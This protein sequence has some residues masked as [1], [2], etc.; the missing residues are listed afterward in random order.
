MHPRIDRSVVLPEPEGPMSSVSSPVCSS[1]STPLSTLTWFGASPRTL[2][3]P[4]ASRMTLL[5]AGWDMGR[6]LLDLAAEDHGRI[7]PDHFDDGAD[8]GED[9]HADRNGEQRQSKLG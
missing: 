3:M 1:R 7:D 5:F 8:G 2:T 6:V 9:T 4:W